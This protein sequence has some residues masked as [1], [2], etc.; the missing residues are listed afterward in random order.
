MVDKPQHDMSCLI[1]ESLKQER[2]RQLIATNRSSRM[3]VL[4]EVL[5]DPQLHI[6]GGA[7]RDAL[8]GI[9]S[10]DLD[11]AT[12]LTA[13]EAFKRL[14]QRHIKTI[15]TGLKHGTITALVEGEPV[16]ITTFR[17]GRHDIAP[18]TIEADLSGRDFT[19]NALAFS[20]ESEQLIDTVGGFADLSAG[21]LRAVGDAQERLKEDPL[22]MVRAVRFGPAAGREMDHGLRDAI[23]AHHELLSRVAVERIRVELEKILMG[24]FPA[25]G[26]DALRSLGLLP[27]TFA[28]LL[29]TIGF[30]QNRYHTKDVYGHTLDV[31]AACPPERILRLAAVYHDIG[32]AYTLTVDKD[33]NRHFY[34]HEKISEEIC[35]REMLH[36]R[37]SYDDIDSVATLVKLHMRPFD[38]GPAGVRR[39]LRDAGDEFPRWREFKNADKPAVFED[40]KLVAMAER[41]DRMVEEER[42]RVVGSF[43]STLA[44]SGDDLKELGFLPGKQMGV[45]LNQ[46]K[47][48]VLD[49]PDKNQRDFLIAFVQE[50]F[51]P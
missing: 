10:F 27:Y 42:H 40:D 41:F 1:P 23:K 46:L 26:V 6:V 29:P 19:I 39:L 30:D 34:D 15:A 50:N 20:C 12:A 48:L 14:E 21:I 35:R 5:A 31:L 25:A 43:K 33:G 45:I 18:H 38:C 3:M 37:F 28:E 32:K 36:L 22:R 7:V 49:D 11:L 2:L 9:A 4:R 13:Q 24:E 17:A 51:Q 8:L 16:E 44:I 47:E